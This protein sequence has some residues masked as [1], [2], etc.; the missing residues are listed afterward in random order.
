MV[1]NRVHQKVLPDEKAVLLTI[2]EVA[3][4]V[5]VHI[6]TVYRWIQ[7][8]KLKAFKFGPRLYGVEKRALE[9]FIDDCGY[10]PIHNPP[11]V[12]PRQRS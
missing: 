7:D 12:G 2:P 5:R 11:D 1:K 4:W 10:G 3:L 6:K 9:Q 8:A